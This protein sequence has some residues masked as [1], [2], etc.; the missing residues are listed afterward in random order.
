[1]KRSSGVLIVLRVVLLLSGLMSLTGSGVL[2][3]PLCSLSS[4]ARWSAFPTALQSYSAKQGS[5]ASYGESSFTTFINNMYDA[6]N[7][8]LRISYGSSTVSNY[9]NS[10]IAWQG[11]LD[12]ASFHDAHGIPGQGW[13]S[14]TVVS[15]VQDLVT[16][17]ESLSG[18][19]DAQ[20]RDGYDDDMSWAIH[21]LVKLWFHTGQQSYLDSATVL[22]DTVKAQDDTTCCGSHPGGVW[23]D[24]AH[25]SKATA[26]QAGITVAALRLM[27]TSHATE[28]TQSQWLAYA[29][30]HYSFWKTNFVNTGNGQVCDHEDTSG[31]LVWWGFTYNNGE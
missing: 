16:T 27:E 5:Y 21:G 2:A 22:F 28:Y 6:T 13:G 23:W 7:R 24:T 26:A 30:S 31:N 12:Y 17:Q 9:W 29:Q 18:E 19:N 15:T 1:M 25:T 20:L 8:R 4:S 3:C 14:A 11:L 10:A